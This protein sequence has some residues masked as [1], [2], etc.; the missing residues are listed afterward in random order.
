MGEF[1]RKF[2]ENRGYPLPKLVK[3]CTSFCNFILGLYCVEKFTQVILYVVCTQVRRH[4]HKIITKRRYEDE[5]QDFCFWK[6]SFVHS[7]SRTYYAL[8]LGYFGLKLFP[9]IRHCVYWVVAEIWAPN[10][11]NRIWNKNCIHHCQG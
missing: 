9:N 8:L 5:S 7:R 11:C 4:V 2:I 10:S 6:T 3:F 1:F